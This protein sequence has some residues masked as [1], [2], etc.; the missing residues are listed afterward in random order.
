MNS[1]GSYY[2]QAVY[3]GSSYYPSASGAKEPFTVLQYNPTICTSIYYWQTCY[4][5]GGCGSYGGCGNCYSGGSQYTQLNSGAVLIGTIVKDEA[6]VTGVNGVTPTGTVMFYLYWSNGTLIGS[7]TAT[8]SSGVAWSSP[9]TM[10]STGSYYFQA[11]YSGSSYYYKICG[12]EELFT[13]IQH[14]PI[15]FCSPF[16]YGCETIYNY[17]Y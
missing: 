5:Y 14:Y 7:S 16:G 9:V 4:G 3:S 8:L 11:V 17:L 1:T 10:N 2:F 6:I 15:G 12:A 13:V